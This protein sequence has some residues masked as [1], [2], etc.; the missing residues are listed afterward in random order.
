MR[1]TNYDD[2][3][4][5]RG[6]VTYRGAVNYSSVVAGIQTGVE[7]SPDLVAEPIDATDVRRA[8]TYAA[9]SDLPLT[10]KLTGHG[11]MSVDS[12]LII[13]TSRLATIRIDPTLLVAEVGSGAIWRDVIAAAAKYGL[14]PLHGTAGTVGV[15]G[16][17]LG[18]GFGP[19]ARQ[20]GYAADHVIDLDLVTP[21]GTLRHVTADSEPDLFWAARGAGRHLGIVTSLRFRL[22]PIRH[23]Y[24]G[25]LALNV[26]SWRQAVEHYLAWTTGIPQQMS[27]SL[28][29]MNFPNSPE[30]PES[31]RGKRKA[32]IYVSYLGSPSEADALLLPLRKLPLAADTVAL[33]SSAELSS[34][35]NEPTHPHAYQGDAVAARAVNPAALDAELAYLSSPDISSPTFLFLHHLGGAMATPATPA[36]AIGHRQAQY[37]IRMIS[38]TGPESDPR[39]VAAEQD[40]VLG[41]LADQPSGRMINFL[42]GDND[43]PAK[44]RSCYDPAD[45][46]RLVRIKREIDPD[47]LIR[48]SRGCLSVDEL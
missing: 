7:V 35:F 44:L 15:A 12:G 13:D 36:N 5:F 4:N 22:F 20:H 33:M 1:P 32:T 8:V 16:Y 28:S 31:I 18:G 38:S 24:A 2:I 14:A 46:D 45:F 39:T 19:L 47:N 10:A 6:K 48:L 34:I 17:T 29:L 26:D 30:L 25:A 27:S 23:V 3:E 37:L 41:T 11:A 40:K 42:F 43:T 21:D 9:R